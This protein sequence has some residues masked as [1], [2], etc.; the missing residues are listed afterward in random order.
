[1]TTPRPALPQPADEQELVANTRLW[2]TERQSKTVNA[3]LDAALDE[4]REQGY[5]QLTIRNVATRA[6]VTHTTAYSYFTSKAHLTAELHWRQ[7][8]ALPLPAEPFGDA[9]EDHVVA[10]FEAPARLMADEP[11]LAAASAVAMLAPEPEVRRLREAVGNDLIQRLTITLGDL[12][13]PE[14]ID[15]LML[16]Y[17]GAMLNAGLGNFTF[18]VVVERMRSIGRLIAPDH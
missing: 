13:T 18:E 5:E 4:L 2:L 17:A 15:A 11:N 14:L 6:G 8:R 12:A 9:F 1:M 3:L 7:V 16:S 10:A